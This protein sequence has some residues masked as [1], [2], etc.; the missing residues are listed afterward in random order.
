MMGHRFQLSNIVMMNMIPKDAGYMHLDVYTG[1]KIKKETTVKTIKQSSLHKT[2][3]S[4][5]PPEA[6]A[7]TFSAEGLPHNKDIVS[8]STLLYIVLKEQQ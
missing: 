1:R 2:Y 3:Y 8:H 7:T 5:L 6:A 4:L